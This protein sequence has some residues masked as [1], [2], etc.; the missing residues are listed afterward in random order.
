MFQLTIEQPQDAD[1][2]EALLD[3]AFGPGRRS[4]TSYR[5]RE[6]VDPVPGLSLVARREDRIV[7]SIR[8]WPVMVGEEDRPALLLGTLANPPQPQGPGTGPAPSFHHPEHG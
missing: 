4:K 3:E 1:E 2:I 8:Y 6:G 7:G 5:Y